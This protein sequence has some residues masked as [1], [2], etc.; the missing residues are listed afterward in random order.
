LLIAQT[1]PARP[2]HPGKRFLLSRFKEIDDAVNFISAEKH[3]KVNSSSFDPLRSIQILANIS[4]KAFAKLLFCSFEQVTKPMLS[5][6][7]QGMMR[8]VH[9]QPPFLKTWH[10]RGAEYFSDQE[11]FIVDIEKFRALRLSP[12]MFWTPC[13]KH[14]DALALGHCVLYDIPSRENNDFSF[15]AVA[16]PCSCDVKKSGFLAEVAACLS[17]MR[18]CDPKSET[19]QIE[20]LEPRE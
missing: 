6:V 3:G 9:G 1:E 7:Y 12:L 13:A 8:A 18:Q 10:F 17:S 2:Q 11:I 16:Y 5:S 20:T 19:I 15:K 14:V 4:Q